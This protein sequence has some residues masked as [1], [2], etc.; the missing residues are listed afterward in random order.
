MW[1]LDPSKCS[2]VIYDFGVGS[3]KESSGEVC[4]AISILYGVDIFSFVASL[5]FDS[6]E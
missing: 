5:I 3:P 4:F 6:M 2:H 1:P